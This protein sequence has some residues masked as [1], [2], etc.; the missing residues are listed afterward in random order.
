M[1]ISITPANVVASETATVINSQ[2]S[3]ETIEAGDVVIKTDEGMKKASA[4]DSD[5]VN[6]SGIALVS[7]EIGQPCPYVE[8]DAEIDLGATLG[9]GDALYLSPT[10]G[11]LTIDKADIVSG[12]TP[13][14]CGAGVGSN[15]A[16]INFSTPMP[17]QAL[18]AN[19]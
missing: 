1:D 17:F 5:L 19:A 11:K 10:P 15:K 7:S 13:V 8:Q 3:A 6:A 16:S 9:A 12:S 4:A 14:L 2:R 18:E